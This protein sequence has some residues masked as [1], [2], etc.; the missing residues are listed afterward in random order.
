MKIFFFGVLCLF[1]AS[2]VYA[3][4]NIE[5][6]ASPQAWAAQ[7]TVAKLRNNGFEPQPLPKVELVAQQKLTSTRLL[8]AASKDF[9]DLYSQTL[10]ITVASSR[11][12]QP[13]KRF[14]VNA[15]ISEQEC[16]I[17]DPLIIDYALLG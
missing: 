2:T 11:P 14:I 17:A 4:S 5:Y 13:I 12:E 8:P 7:L 9:G 3:A 6:C 10:L 1:L 16:S 15:I